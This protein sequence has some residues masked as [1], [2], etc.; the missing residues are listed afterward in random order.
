MKEK[1]SIKDWVYAAI[2]CIAG[3]IVGG[4]FGEMTGEFYEGG[5]IF[6]K[7]SLPMET[8]GTIAGAICGVVVNWKFAGCIRECKNESLGFLVN[9]GLVKGVVLGVKAGIATHIICIILYFGFGFL[10]LV[11]L[12]IGVL[13]GA[14]AGGIAGVL[15]SLV[16]IAFGYYEHVKHKYFI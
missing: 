2:C 16:A 5:E 3:A 6:A 14:I 11:S 9:T 12:L 1:L 13:M 8:I 15:L 7:S 10:F 4:F